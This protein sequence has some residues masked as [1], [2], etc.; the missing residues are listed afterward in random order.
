MCEI[1][2]SEWA[3]WAFA[4]L[5]GLLLILT[6]LSI[7]ALLKY[8]FRGFFAVQRANVIAAGEDEV[9]ND[10]LAPEILKLNGLAVH[11]PE[12]ELRCIFIYALEVFFL[13]ASE[14]S[15]RRPNGPTRAT[16]SQPSSGI[17][18]GKSSPYLILMVGQNGCT[19]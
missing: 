4:G 3:G 2:M 14:D 12:G 9:E 17:G 6:L 18:E 15:T 19:A 13:S 16:L 11:G 5:G 1:V 7:A 8:L 10:A